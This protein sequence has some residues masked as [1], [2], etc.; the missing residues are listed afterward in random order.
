MSGDVVRINLHDLE[1]LEDLVDVSDKVADR[2]KG[3]TGYQLASLMR[4]YAWTHARHDTGTMRD[5]ITQAGDRKTIIEGDKTTVRIGCS[6]YYAVFQEYGTGTKGDP[7]IP[8]V[9]KSVWWQYDGTDAEGNPKFLK[10]YAQKP[11]Y[12]M[13]RAI[14]DPGQ[15]SLF[16]EV[17]AGDL[18]KVFEE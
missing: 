14:T 7:A 9:Q 15:L 3:G 12:F 5:S 10:R 1:H 2:L 11:T 17:L 8:H 18:K 13:R 6:A 4:D 16:K